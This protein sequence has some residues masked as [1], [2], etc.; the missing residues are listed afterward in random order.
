MRRARGSLGLD[1]W[2]CLC[3]RHKIG[4]VRLHAAQALYVVFRSH[5]VRLAFA[6][7]L[8]DLLG[9]ERAALALLLQ[10]AHLTE[11]FHVDLEEQF[12]PLLL[13]VLRARRHGQRIV[14]S[15][16]GLLVGGSAGR[17][18]G[19]LLRRWLFELVG[20]GRG[21]QVRLWRRSRVLVVVGEG[22][23]RGWCGV[24]GIILGRGGGR[25]VV[26]WTGQLESRLLKLK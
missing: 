21:I 7:Q 23:A 8:R 20:V 3:L 13:P 1:V 14:D 2:V 15:R 25:I 6:S 26:C 10:S 4:Q 18:H 12:Y 5:L 22:Q 11:E 16:D 9:A 24:G 19:I 17:G